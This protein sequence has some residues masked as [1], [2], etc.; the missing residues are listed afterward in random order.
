MNTASQRI[1][2]V[3]QDE[4][5]GSK[6]KLFLRSREHVAEACTNV[7]DARRFLDHFSC[8]IVMVDVDLPES[9]ALE[10]CYSLLL[11][12]ATSIDWRRA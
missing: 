4:G 10:L 2:I 8:D 5:M 11:M 12:P 1:L 7:E 3:D 9:G 6:L